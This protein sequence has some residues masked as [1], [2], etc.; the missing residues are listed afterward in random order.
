VCLLAVA[1]W[2]SPIGEHLWFGALE[3]GG[4]LLHPLT[5]D[6]ETVSANARGMGPFGRTSHH[7]V[8][9]RDVIVSA[10]LYLR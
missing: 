3:V 4:R 2:L 8:E 5:L 6:S 7:V 9:L 1:T 10:V